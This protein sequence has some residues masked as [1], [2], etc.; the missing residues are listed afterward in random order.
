MLQKRCFVCGEPLE[1]ATRVCPVCGA[2][3]AEPRAS[4]GDDVPKAEPHLNDAQPGEAVFPSDAAETLSAAEAA[5]A[6]GKA[7]P[8]DAP[9]SAE[10]HPFAVAEPRLVGPYK[11][12]T[13]RAISD[14]LTEALTTLDPGGAWAVSSDFLEAST[15]IAVREMDAKDQRP[16][17]RLAAPPPIDLSEVAAPP[18]RSVTRRAFLVGGLG[19]VGLAMA[20]SLTLW[21]KRPR[22]AA[23]PGNALL[24][25]H[26]HTQIVTA[27]AW[28]PNQRR[29]ASASYDGTAQVWDAGSGQRAL[30]YAG[31]KTVKAGGA[32]VV[33][34]VAWSPDGKRLAS[35]GE[36]QTVQVW[37][38]ATGKTLFTYRGHKG[39]VHGL[40]WSPD[41][42]RI[43][44][45][46]Y[47]YTVQV[48][49]AVDGKHPL[50]YKGHSREALAVAWSPNG[51]RLV[52]SSNDYTAQ[53]WDA[54]T[55]ANQLTYKGH[56]N[57]GAGTFRG[58]YSVA[59]SRD[60]GRIAS[61][62]SDGTAQI[63]NA[64]TG[65]TILTYHAL[66]DDVRAV[67]WS[68]DGTRLACAG[69][70]S[71]AAQVLDAATGKTLFTAHCHQ[72]IVDALAWSPDGTRIASG[73]FD[74]TAC[75]WA[76]G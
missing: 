44:S 37:D 32:P 2:S 18:R 75:I 3:V 68:P 60:G 29:L 72:L 65:K 69:D 41:G 73:S 16:A 42:T 57:L 5:P 33:W 61:G 21:I 24:T 52:S 38:A 8:P 76:I 71:G 1:H 10:P 17:A 54:A 34:D 27:V 64:T 40:A 6:E 67:T 50:V 22:V 25:Y 14:D 36:D 59:W 43:A 48:W 19:V 58:V 39:L 31:H 26:G 63:W 66:A 9:R 12:G 51:K 20:G 62:A 46:S 7:L 56:K 35:A 45:A 55:G 74:R 47:D 13:G 53:V 4:D 49:D 23:L 11:S 15:S 70:P 28:S 30:V